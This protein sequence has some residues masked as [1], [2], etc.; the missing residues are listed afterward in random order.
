MLRFAALFKP[1]PLPLAPQGRLASNAIA[2]RGDLTL[3]SSQCI[4]DI[5][6]IDEASTDVKLTSFKRM[7][8][9]HRKQQQRAVLSS[10][11]QAGPPCS[12][13]E[14]AGG[15]AGEVTVPVFQWSKAPP[16]ISNLPHAGQPDLWN[17]PLLTFTAR[18]STA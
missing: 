10:V 6:P 18:L 3:A 17:F 14:G 15:R 1:L 13:E 2:E 16:R 7:W 12:S 5:G 8:P 11:A 4:S 9:Q